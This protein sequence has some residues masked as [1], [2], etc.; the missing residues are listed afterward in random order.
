MEKANA[1]NNLAVRIE[2]GSLA[3]TAKKRRGTVI[4]PPTRLPVVLDLGQPIK[5]ER[6]ENQESRNGG[7]PEQRPSIM[8]AKVGF[9][10][11]AQ[12][13][14]KPRGLQVWCNIKIRRDGHGTTPWLRL[15][16]NNQI[17]C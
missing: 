11:V 4:E 9:P 15:P 10:Y 1:I 17:A 7:A 8:I 6:P 14:V 5:S 12:G 13:P 2:V 3:R 16:I